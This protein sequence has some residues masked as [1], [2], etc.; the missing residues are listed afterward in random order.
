MGNINN[1]VS[2]K[3]DVINLILRKE[4]KL[5]GVWN[6]NYKNPKKD[7]WK[8]IINFFK[9]GFRPSKFI[10]HQIKAHDMLNMQF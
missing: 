2:I 4:L 7:D 10:S 9:K 5:F 8:E 6:S 3:K 1:N